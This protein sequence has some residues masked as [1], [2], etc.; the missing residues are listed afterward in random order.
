METKTNH[1]CRDCGVLLNDNNWYL[2][3]QKKRDYICK[4]CIN[5][6]IK[7]WQ[8]A[9]PDKAK[10]IWTRNNR[11][12]G[13]RPMSENRECSSFLGVYV[14]ERVLSHV[15]ANVHRMPI[16]NPGYD[17]ICG[18]GYMIDAKGS[19]LN[20]YGRWQFNINHNIIADYF[21]CLAFDNRKDL[22]PL[23]VWLIPGKKINHL[24]ATG[25][26]LSTIHKWDKYRLDVS[27]VA[28]CC[29]TLRNV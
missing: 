4:K 5:E 1:V 23:H 14:A 25:I 8:K 18:K 22:N 3:R 9:N 7:Q 21:L 28:T 29:N 16:N 20:K 26:S 10:T 17:F 11:K 24:R 12:H 15:F 2:S 19:C 6:R 13:N 27:K